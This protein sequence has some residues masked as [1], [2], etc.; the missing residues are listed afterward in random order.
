[1]S[2]SVES[3]T[4]CPAHQGESGRQE[5]GEGEKMV[6]NL[7]TRNSTPERQI[8][9][10]AGPDPIDY[11]LPS[12]QRHAGASLRLSLVVFAVRIRL[13]LWSRFIWIELKLTATSRSPMPRKP[14]TPRMTAAT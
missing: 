11:F 2:T 4:G 5:C 3:D 6:R 1:M 7:M 14:P 12:S 8:R 10:D 13:L 9:A